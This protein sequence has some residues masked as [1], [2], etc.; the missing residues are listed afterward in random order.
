M[1]LIYL[2]LDVATASIALSP[3]LSARELGI[4]SSASA[5]ALTAY[6]SISGIWSALFLTAIEQANSEAPPP[7]TILLVL[8]RFLTTHMASWILL[9]ASSTIIWDPP[10]TRMVTDLLLTH[11][12]TISILS[13]EVPN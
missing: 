10:L 12:S 4:F 1:S 8:I 9:I 13:F 2:L 7:Q 6:Y 11:S 5:N 3:E